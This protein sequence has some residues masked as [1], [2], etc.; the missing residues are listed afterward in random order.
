METK[1][2]NCWYEWETKSN[3]LYITCPNCLRKFEW[4][5]TPFISK[6][7]SRIIEEHCKKHRKDIKPSHKQEKSN[8][9]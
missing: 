7:E 3:M 5:D 6:Q 2:P 8:G 1:C 4:G 9:S